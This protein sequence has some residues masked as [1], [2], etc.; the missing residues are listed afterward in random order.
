MPHFM[1]EREEVLHITIVDVESRQ[2][3]NKRRQLYRSNP[4]SGSKTLPPTMSSPVDNTLSTSPTSILVDTDATFS[5]RE[6]GSQRHSPTLMRTIDDE[7][8][9]ERQR[10]MDVDSAMQLCALCFSNTSSF[11]D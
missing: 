5:R 8:A 9:R 4:A 3:A 1:Q 2:D 10:A 11:I 6:D 7:E